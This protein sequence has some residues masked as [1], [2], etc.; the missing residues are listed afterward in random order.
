MKNNLQENKGI[1]NTFFGGTTFK[2]IL[3]Y[4]FIII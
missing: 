1:G 3:F 4:N 2:L